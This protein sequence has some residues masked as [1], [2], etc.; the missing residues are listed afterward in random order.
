MGKRKTANRV[1]NILNLFIS[2]CV[3]GTGLILFLKFH[4]GNGAHRT[5]WLGLGKAFWLL[6]HQASAIGFLTGSTFHLQRHW[7]YIKMVAK[8]W[9]RN[10]PPR[11][12]STTREQILLLLAALVVMWAGFYAWIAMPQATLEVK[13]YHRWID[14]HN[15]AG[16][17]FLTGMNVHI[18]R[19]WR[20]LF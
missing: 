13:E 17:F 12:K 5:E 2:V 11:V 4:T 20:R 8:R 9:R 19:R 14:V 15:I 3:F 10:L 16:L 7:K 1:L 18:K 6:I